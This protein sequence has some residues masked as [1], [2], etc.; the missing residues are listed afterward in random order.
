MPR[1]C[2]Y[3]RERNQLSL[4]PAVGVSVA[5]LAISWKLNCEG[6]PEINVPLMSLRHIQILGDN[7]SHAATTR[8]WQWAFPRLYFFSFTLPMST[9]ETLCYSNI[10]FRS[11][12]YLLHMRQLFSHTFYFCFTAP[13]GKC[14]CFLRS[15]CS[16]VFNSRLF[17]LA[18]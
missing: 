5:V 9:R 16:P 8:C 14:M 13:P 4:F 18:L 1:A 3:T 17:S 12:H 6:M 10:F 2:I 7:H 15:E 11:N